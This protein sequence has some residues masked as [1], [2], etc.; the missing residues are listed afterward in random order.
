MKLWDS[1]DTLPIYY[2]WEVVAS[3][4][5]S[6]I[7]YEGDVNES[8]KFEVEAAWNKIEEE[9]YDM[10][11]EDKKYLEDLKEEGRYYS[12]MIRAEIGTPLDKIYF[13]AEKTLYDKKEETPFNY[14]DSISLLEEKLK[15]AIDD[16]TWPV[17]RYY[18]H[19]KRIKNNGTEKS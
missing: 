6:H 14:H 11:A 18:S 3:G 16:R 19:L 4:N 13:K 12:K 17:R 1:I 8:N 7:V 5:L 10:L 9:F 2:Y 15:F